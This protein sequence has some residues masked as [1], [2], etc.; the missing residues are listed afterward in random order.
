MPSRSSRARAFLIVLIGL[1]ALALPLAA[2]P[3]VAAAMV[4]CCCGEHDA[5]H[6]CGCKDC[7]AGHRGDDHAPAEPSVKA[8]GSASL[9][10]SLGGAPALPLP[11]PTPVRELITPAAPAAAPTLRLLLPDPPPSPPPRR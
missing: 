9:D 10:V 8:C 5:G 11:A 4:R 1:C 3:T 7:P 2:I 6:D